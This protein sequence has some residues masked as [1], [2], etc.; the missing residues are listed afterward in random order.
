MHETREKITDL[1]RRTG[2]GKNKR[3]IVVTVDD[4]ERIDDN[5]HRWRRYEVTGPAATGAGRF[6]TLLPGACPCDLPACTASGWG[7]DCAAAKAKA[8]GRQ[9]RRDYC[10]GNHPERAVAFAEAVLA[11]YGKAS[12]TASRPAAISQRWKGRRHALA[13]LDGEESVT[14]RP[15]GYRYSSADRWVVDCDSPR[16]LVRDDEG[17]WLRVVSEHGTDDEAHEAKAAHITWH[18]ERFGVHPR[19]RLDWWIAANE[20]VA[21]S[22]PDQEELQRQLAIARAS[23]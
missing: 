14:V 12:H 23:A 19:V 15:V 2:K 22:E 5:G 7:R 9:H 17:R 10:H 21:A 18:R 3:T 20:Q 11:T 16:C 4:V 8:T 6:V 1:D 13:P